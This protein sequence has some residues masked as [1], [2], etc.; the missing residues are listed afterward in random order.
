[1]HFKFLLSALALLSTSGRLVQASPSLN[2]DSLDLVVRDPLPSIDE[3]H[4]ERR[5]G[6]AGKALNIIGGI[7]ATIGGILTL[8]PELVAYGAVLTIVG[9]AASTVGA[10]VSRR[11]GEEIN[12]GKILAADEPALSLHSSKLHS[13]GNWSTYVLSGRNLEAGNA[14]WMEVT[15]YHKTNRV[16]ALVVG[17]KT[18]G[19]SRRQGQN[20][21]HIKVSFN[22]LDRPEGG[23]D[24]EQL[25]RFAES[26]ASK[27]AAS[28]KDTSCHGSIVQGK[29]VFNGK[30]SIGTLDELKNREVINDCSQDPKAYS[31]YF[32]EEHV[33]ATG[34]FQ[35]SSAS[36]LTL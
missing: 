14:V 6:D 32:N 9:S 29:K 25:N 30:I 12:L 16:D 24:K 3:H 7:A 5:G 8:Q 15:H 34:Q 18:N 31:Q 13:S 33:P 10:I 20:D 1:M 17:T 11:D 4:L 22:A 23:F 28:K 27:V 36:F 21:Q 19:L 26:M 35:A 2:S